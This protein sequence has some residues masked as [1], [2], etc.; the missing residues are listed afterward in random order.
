[1]PV[2]KGSKGRAHHGTAWLGEVPVG[3]CVQGVHAVVNTLVQFTSLHSAATLLCAVSPSSVAG[4]SLQ[5]NLVDSYDP[6]LKKHRAVLLG[7]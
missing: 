1:M 2:A 7:L 4:A 6:A 5:G 3:D